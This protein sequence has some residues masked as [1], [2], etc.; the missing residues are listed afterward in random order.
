MVETVT[1]RLDKGV[2]KVEVERVWSDEQRIVN[3][4]N[5]TFKV[6]GKEITIFVDRRHGGKVAIE[7]IK[8]PFQTAIHRKYVSDM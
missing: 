3:L 4:P 6:K 8:R 2:S 1:A 7:E 5:L